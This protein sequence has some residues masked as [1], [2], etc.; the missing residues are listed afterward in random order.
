MGSGKCSFS[1]NEHLSITV[2]E[3]YTGDGGLKGLCLGAPNYT[4]VHAL[5]E[6]ALFR[7]LFVTV[8]AE[9]NNNNHKRTTN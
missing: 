1:S 7:M 8:N 5:S 2:T 6:T 9:K 3:E 4:R